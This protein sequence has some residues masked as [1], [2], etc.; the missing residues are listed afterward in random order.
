M[1]H[2]IHYPERKPMT[3]PTCLRCGAKG[4]G[5]TFPLTPRTRGARFGDICSSCDDSNPWNQPTMICVDCD[6]D[7]TVDTAYGNHK[8]GDPRCEDCHQEFEE[9]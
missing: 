6:M 8:Y 5:H 4:E 7:L 2:E 9:A 1:L 3:Q